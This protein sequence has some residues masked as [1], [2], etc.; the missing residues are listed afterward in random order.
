MLLLFNIHIHI[1]Y[2]RLSGQ[3]VFTDF[4]HIKKTVSPWISL[5]ANESISIY[6]PFGTIY[7]KVNTDKY[8]WRTFPL[9]LQFGKANH[10]GR[11]KVTCDSIADL[12]N[13]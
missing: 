13:K 6:T 10:Y 12:K 8:F 1:T 7:P 11:C 3:N 9:P 2:P 5:L 4:L